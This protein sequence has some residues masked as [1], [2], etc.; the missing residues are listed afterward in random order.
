MHKYNNILTHIHIA[1][2]H[3]GCMNPQDELNILRTQFIHRIATIQFDILSIDGD[4]FDRRLTADN[5]AIQAGIQFVNECASLCAMRNAALILISG[6][7][8]HDSGQLAIFEGMPLYGAE[9]YIVRKTQFVETHG[10]KIL[11]IPEEYSKGASY[12]DFFLKEQ[13][14]MVFMHGTLVNSIPGATEENLNSNREP[15]FSIDSF[16]G[17]LGP[18][19]AGHVHVGQC[20]QGHMY[21]ISSPVRWKFGE[22]QPKGY[23]IALYY[24]S[25]HQYYNQFME[26]NSYLY[27]TISIEDLNTDD[28]NIIIKKLE[29]I[30]NHGVDYI[31]LNCRNVPP[32]TLEI[33]RK[34]Y[35]E[36]KSPYVKLYNVSK[37]S[38]DMD[39]VDIDRTGDENILTDVMNN[40]GFLLDDRIDALTK[41]VL[42]VNANNGSDIISIDSLK[43]ILAGG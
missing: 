33:I 7:E 11:C 12:Y 15:V 36:M 23:I 37:D 32:H 20:I 5:L 28:P 41:F 27:N 42:Y 22:E 17:C 3:F 38:K 6:T 29:N 14:D 21:Y 16:S 4:L 35:H 10:V 25:T 30:H 1:D 13:Y 40:M 8:S 18:I 26:I 39:L 2:I 24:K 31:R 9:V 43:K 34:Y 19:Y